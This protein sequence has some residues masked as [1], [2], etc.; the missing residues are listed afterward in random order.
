MILLKA[1]LDEIYVQV[2][3]WCLKYFNLIS[4]SHVYGALVPDAHMLS[5]WK[6][7]SSAFGA[8]AIA[9]I[10]SWWSNERFCTQRTLNRSCRSQAIGLYP[11]ERATCS[12]PV[13]LSELHLFKILTAQ[14]TAFL[15]R[16]TIPPLRR[17]ISFDSLPQIE[18]IYALA[19]LV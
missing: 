4:F 8:H 9:L 19:C 12:T 2:L 16:T 7:F 3:S 18:S 1:I 14:I 10:C 11:C 17:L 5:S 6:M 13:E 15:Y